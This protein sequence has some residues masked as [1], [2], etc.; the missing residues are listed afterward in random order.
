MPTVTITATIRPK[1]GHETE[2]EKHFSALLEPTHAEA[3]CELY[4]LHRVAERPGELLFIER[5]TSAEDLAAHA[6]SDHIAACIAACDGMLE[7]P[8]DIANL[9]TVG[10]GD[11]AK[12]TV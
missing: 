10:G 11:S 9:E 8:V 6:A 3:G 5:W 12:G 1:P 7:G 4:A 2:V